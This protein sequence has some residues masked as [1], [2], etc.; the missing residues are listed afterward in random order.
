[1]VNDC[2]WF[3]NVCLSLDLNGSLDLFCQWHICC[4]CLLL[5]IL[6]CVCLIRGSELCLFNFGCVHDYDLIIVCCTFA[7]SNSDLYATCI[8]NIGYM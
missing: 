1:M 8:S 2:V 3:I 6:R 7:Q 5:S 4:F